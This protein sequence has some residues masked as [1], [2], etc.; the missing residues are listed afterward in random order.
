MANKNMLAQRSYQSAKTSYENFA[1]YS[2]YEEVQDIQTPKK[3]KVGRKERILALLLTIILSSG[4]SA[5]VIKSKLNKVAKILEIDSISSASGMEF[6]IDDNTI[7][8]FWVELYSKLNLDGEV[9]EIANSYVS[10]TGNLFNNTMGNRPVT[11]DIDGISYE[12]NSFEG[13]GKIFSDGPDII[14]PIKEADLS[15]YKLTLEP[16]GTI[17]VDDEMRRTYSPTLVPKK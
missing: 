11:I 10:K 3:K 12:T 2:N 1:G 13:A 7:D 14:D 8:G 4:V 6:I 9:N 15:S 17:Y 5:S 16:S